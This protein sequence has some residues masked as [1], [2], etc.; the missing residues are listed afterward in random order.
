M[1][2]LV[3]GVDDTRSFFRS[4]LYQLFPMANILL[5]LL[6]AYRI[7]D[8]RT[9]YRAVVLAGA[10]LS[11]VYIVRYSTSELTNDV[12]RF[13]LRD[14]IGHGFLLSAAAGAV[15]M[16]RWRSLP[17]PRSVSYALAVLCLTSVVVSDS[18]T[19]LL[20]MMI[21]L[22]AMVYPIIARRVNATNTI[23]LV[24][25]FAV[26][27][28]PLLSEMLGPSLT[29]SLGRYFN[30]TEMMALDY[31]RFDDINM[32]WRGYEATRAYEFVSNHGT[33]ATFFGMG[34]GT[35]VPLHITIALGDDT[36]SAIGKFH[37]V[38]S[39]LLVRG[40]FLGVALY[41]TQMG[42]FG[43]YIGRPTLMRGDSEYRRFGA[44]M[45]ICALLAGPA[46]T[47][48]YASGGTGATL[49]ILISIIGGSALLRSRLREKIGR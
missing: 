25:L 12:N 2:T 41:A 9:L 34:W 16:A 22:I 36:M 35:N 47:G 30:L 20:S 26:F 11:L 13:E 4:G 14:T 44:G 8:S 45:M 33:L 7:R 18:R 10:I 46:V 28:T 39:Q 1:M 27:T 48:F 29:Q 40:G 42:L 6:L 49:D 43:F 15:A 32:H 23:V 3:W 19:D 17:W 31:S 38:Y 24:C 21:L 5:G 37:S